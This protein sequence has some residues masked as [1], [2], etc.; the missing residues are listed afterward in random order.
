MKRLAALL[1]AGSLIAGV[2][3]AAASTGIAPRPA[4]VV[5]ADTVRLGDLFAGL[6]AALADRPVT[7]AP[8]PGR[9]ALFDAPALARLAAAH[10]V[11]WTP[12]GGA[13]R[14]EVIRASHMIGAAEIADALKSAAL[15]AGAPDTLEVSLDNRSLELHLPASVERGFLLENVRW[16]AARNRLQADL[17]APAVGEPVIRQTVGARAIDM[18][19]VPVLTRRV[20]PGEIITDSDV[21]YLTVARDRLGARAVTEVAA[22]VGHTPRRAVAPNQP[23]RV[24]D[25]RTPVV[26]AKGA[27][28]TI[29]LRTPTMALTAQGR[30]LEDGGQGEVIRVANTSSGRMLEVTVVD[31]GLVTVDPAGMPL[32]LPVATKHAKAQRAAAAN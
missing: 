11:A 3:P 2:T 13:D 17:V 15:D 31:G 30:A 8:A 20:A 9:R 14:V 28:V 29:A 6:D 12:A 7:T 4:A 16:D 19:E 5:D 10:G 32:A 27:I 22:L 21:A 1:L 24:A 25:I 23:V 26:V 18:V